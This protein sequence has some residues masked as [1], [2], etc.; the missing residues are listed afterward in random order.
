MSLLDSE[1]DMGTIV[2]FSCFMYFCT[3]EEEIMSLDV[4]R[5][6][7]VSGR[8]EVCY[9]TKDA[10]AKAGYRY[11]AA[12]GKITFEP[13]ETEKEITVELL[14]DDTWQTTLEFIV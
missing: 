1:G 4:M 5:I 13:G 3:E 2:Q 10:T 11:K 9:T 8:S 14:P 6:G 12:H 7:D